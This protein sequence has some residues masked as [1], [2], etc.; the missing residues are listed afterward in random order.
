MTGEEGF[1]KKKMKK[2]SGAKGKN[3]NRRTPSKNIKS[4]KIYSVPKK[5]REDPGKNWEKKHIKRWAIGQKKQI[6]EGNKKTVTKFLNNEILNQKPGKGKL[7]NW[8]LYM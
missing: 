8:K 7:L 3:K 2:K 6:E 5:I 4:K 1:I